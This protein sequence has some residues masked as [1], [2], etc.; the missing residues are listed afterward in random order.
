MADEAVDEKGEGSGDGG[1]K[2]G[3]KMGL[4]LALVAVLLAVGGGLAVYFFVISPKLAPGEEGDVAEVEEPEDFIP[5]NPVF[6]PFDQA[7][8][9]IMREGDGASSM[10]MYKVTLE[11][12]NDAT[13]LRIETHRARFVDMLDKLHGSRTRDEVDDILSFKA[14]IQRQALQKSNDILKRVTTDEDKEP[15]RVTAVFHEQLAVSDPPG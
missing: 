13:A 8:T 1:K 5:L 10:L 9:H 7:I 14:S 15:L 6:F 3:G 2:S 11:C 12:T 4:I